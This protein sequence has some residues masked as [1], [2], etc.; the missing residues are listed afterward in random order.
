[1]TSLEDSPIIPVVEE[2][3]IKKTTQKQY[4]H[5]ARAR[6]IK[7]AKS[8]VKLK[9]SE[10]YVSELKNVHL[11]LERLS[12]QFNTFSSALNLQAPVG[13]KRKLDIT[14]EEDVSEEP[15]KKLKTKEENESPSEW[16]KLFANIVGTAT[17]LGSLYLYKRVTSPDPD[18]QHIRRYEQFTL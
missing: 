10:S 1:M 3:T 12:H 14:D 18:K 9:Q 15:L 7:A 8:E 4:D 5:L 6:Q 2:P 13:S 16:L 17:A 11:H